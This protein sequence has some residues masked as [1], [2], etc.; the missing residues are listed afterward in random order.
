MLIE[1]KLFLTNDVRDYISTLYDIKDIQNKNVT[2]IALKYPLYIELG[3]FM[4][5][6]SKY[7]TVDRHNTL[8]NYL[9]NIICSDDEFYTEE[10]KRKKIDA[11]IAHIKQENSLL[12]RTIQAGTFGYLGQDKKENQQILKAMEDIKKKI[13]DMLKGRSQKDC[14]TD[15]MEILNKYFKTGHNMGPGK[16]KLHNEIKKTLKNANKSDAELFMKFFNFVKCDSDTNCEKYTVS[17]EKSTG[18]R[19]NL[20]KEGETIILLE[21]LK[22][23]NTKVVVTASDSGMFSSFFNYIWQHIYAIATTVA[24]AMFSK[25]CS[26]YN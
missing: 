13:P 25:Y 19:L 1:N 9:V 24:I 7:D 5:N 12:T 6:I 14:K 21:L 11:F 22:G 10:L 15:I 2:T 20:K 26:K 23:N 16:M 8:K 18:S 4:E 3:K 17:D